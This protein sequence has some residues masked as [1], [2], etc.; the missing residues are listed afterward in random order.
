MKLEIG[1]WYE[2]VGL[3]T[4][5]TSTQVGGID[6]II[7]SQ[8]IESNTSLIRL[9]PWA[10]KV[11]GTGAYNLNAQTTIL[12]A[13]NQTKNVTTKYDL[14]NQM[15]NMKLY[16]TDSYPFQ[17]ESGEGY[18]LDGTYVFDFIV[19][20]NDDGS[21]VASI[22]GLVALQ[23]SG[24][25]RNWIVDITVELPTIA[26]S[27][28]VG[29]NSFYL[30]NNATISIQSSSA[31]FVHTLEFSFPSI[32]YSGVI[33][34]KKSNNTIIWD[35]L[36]YDYILQQIPN[37]QSINGTI[38]CK[39]YANS[40]SDEQI[41]D[42][43]SCD[44]TAYVEKVVP[45][46]RNI[47]IFDTNEKTFA[48]TGDR[49]SIIRYMS[50][51]KVT[52]TAE[53]Y[54]HATIA[55]Y[56]VR[57]G[58]KII[59]SKESEILFSD[60]V[61]RNYCH[62]EVRDSRNFS[63]SDMFYGSLDDDASIENFID[64]IKLGISKFNM[65]R[66]EST[67]TKLN[68][69]ISGV[70]FN[71]N[72]GVFDNELTLQYRYKEKNGEY[73]EIKYL[74]LSA[75]QNTF[76]LIQELEDEFDF[77]KQYDF[78]FIL[79][80]KLMSIVTT[81]QVEGGHSIVRIGEDY[82]RIAGDLKVNGAIT[83][84]DVIGKNKINI[85]NAVKGTADIDI[86][87]ENLLVSSTE[88][89][90]NAYIDIFGLNPNTN[91]TFSCNFEQ[92]ENLTSV[93][94]SPRHFENINIEIS[95]VSK[96]SKTGEIMT[97]FQTSSSGNIRIYFYSNFTNSTLEAITN[98]SEIQ[99]ELGNTKTSYASCKNFGYESG[100]NENGNWIKYDDGT[101]ACRGTKTFTNQ[102]FSEQYGSVYLTDSAKSINFSQKFA[103]VEECI[104]SIQNFSGGVG[105]ISGDG[106][107]TEMTKFY[108]WHAIPYTLNVTVSYIAFGRWK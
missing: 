20:H 106:C 11:A 53:A 19:S 44:F 85:H 57:L 37:E 10:K 3:P 54:Q 103:S 73:S 77:N 51:P 15:N 107:T 92:R 4:S 70:W 81:V 42:T 33:T 100:S 41:G 48:L 24:Q 69:D 9:R 98:F 75:N 96:E 86:S 14:R 18:L 2:L 60:G 58:S 47:E 97:I 94:I 82:V 99:L 13:D 95:A 84:A 71:G 66:E 8:S 38:T 63:S 46:M 76:S 40:L 43:T 25:G 7:V 90:A 61:D 26:R 16:L 6:V 105:G 5:S 83:L 108:L 29:C 31:S 22:Y 34:T 93:R 78:E 104:L 1:K 67:S 56:L 27:S 35:Q 62:Y 39:T 45:K 50:K 36:D 21:K 17:K 55:R 64:Y 12:K 23:N 91:Y 87:D 65:F 28:K 49:T 72:F 59:E 102:N 52:I 74:T 30:G 88:P 32:N 68:V 101:M 89:F 80:D 79:S